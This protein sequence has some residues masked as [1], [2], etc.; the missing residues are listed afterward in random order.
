MSEKWI[1]KIK[2]KDDFPLIQVDEIIII[3]TGFVVFFWF[4]HF[5]FVFAISV[6]IWHWFK[7]RYYEQL[8]VRKKRDIYNI[9]YNNA[10]GVTLTFA[11]GKTAEDRKPM[12][13]DLEQL[14]TLRKFLVE[15]FV[16]I[17]LVL[18]ILLGLRG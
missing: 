14:E 10:D 6:L 13:Y 8:I 5:L 7:I 17:N 2:K 15:K 9:Q 12:Y 16:V 11:E 18:L 4:N 3:L 1:D